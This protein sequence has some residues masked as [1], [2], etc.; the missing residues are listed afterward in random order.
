[1]IYVNLGSFNLSAIVNNKISR[2]AKGLVEDL[3]NK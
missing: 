1:M 3:I 2:V